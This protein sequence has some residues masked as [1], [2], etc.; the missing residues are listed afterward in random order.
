[1]PI[2]QSEYK[3]YFQKQ[4]ITSDEVKVHLDKLIEDDRQF[5]AEIVPNVKSFCHACLRSF[6]EK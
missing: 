5:E 4:N 6:C 1:M 2:M 3:Y